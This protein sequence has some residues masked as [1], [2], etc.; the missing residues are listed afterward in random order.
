MRSILRDLTYVSCLFVIALT[1]ALAWRSP[2]VEAGSPHAATQTV[3]Q[4]PNQ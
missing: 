4:Q 2:F 1:I 3:P